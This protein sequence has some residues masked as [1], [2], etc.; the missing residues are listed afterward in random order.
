[1]SDN[2]W[3]STKECKSKAEMSYLR[4][5]KMSLSLPKIRAWEANFGL[6]DD[7]HARLVTDRSV[8]RGSGGTAYLS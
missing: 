4:K 8:D 5:V 3:S 1:M 2:W 6:G 7:E